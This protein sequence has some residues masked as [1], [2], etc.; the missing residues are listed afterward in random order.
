MMG[1]GLHRIS[2]TA[3]PAWRGGWPE[4]S[5][6]RERPGWPRDRPT[7]EPPSKDEVRGSSPRGPTPEIPLG[8]ARPM[9]VGS[10]HRP[11]VVPVQNA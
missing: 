7:R 11:A 9:G 10:G 6:E 1:C 8:F 4:M 3:T 5:T 2:W